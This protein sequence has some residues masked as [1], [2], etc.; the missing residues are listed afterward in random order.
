MN[1][2]TA[3]LM[4]LCA[5][6][7]GCANEERNGIIG[8]ADNAT[9]IVVT[10]SVRTVTATATDRAEQPSIVDSALII[11][12]DKEITKEEFDAINLGDVESFTVLKAP[13]AIK[14]YGEKGEK[15]VVIIEMKKKQ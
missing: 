7:A 4:G 9:G 10:D 15:G 3:F 5:L 11:V 1:R 13:S 14:A 2:K 8:G 12:D 6:M